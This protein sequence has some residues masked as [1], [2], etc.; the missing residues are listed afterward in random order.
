MTFKNN[1]E[2]Y[3]MDYRLAFTLKFWAKNIIIIFFNLP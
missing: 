3:I 2:Y 1:S